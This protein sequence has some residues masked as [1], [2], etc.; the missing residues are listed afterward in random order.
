M[1][2]SRIKFK[3]KEIKKTSFLNQLNSKAK[4]AWSKMNRPINEE[5]LKEIEQQK[6]RIYYYTEFKL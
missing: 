2:L 3:K 1:V 5:R 4:T 6:S